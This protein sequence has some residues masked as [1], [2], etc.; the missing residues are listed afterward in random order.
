MRKLIKWTAPDAL[1]WSMVQAIPPDL[2][3]IYALLHLPTNR[4]YVGFSANIPA[5]LVEHLTAL[6]SNSHSN[7]HLTR[8]WRR[9]GPQ[10]FHVFVVEPVEDKFR[11]LEREDFWIDKL[12]TLYP[13]GFN[14]RKNVN[15]RLSP[16]LARRYM[17]NE[18]EWERY[19][20]ETDSLLAAVRERRATRR[21]GKGR[22]GR[23][24][25]AANVLSVRSR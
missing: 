8:A 22:K 21:K 17:T 14:K 9:D 18:P 6:R 15:T 11:L 25:R 12:C 19:W 7:E 3:G 13:Y 2:C 10:G 20:A 1:F 23:S 16:N 5:R 24:T 4:S